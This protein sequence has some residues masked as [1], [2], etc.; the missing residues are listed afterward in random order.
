MCD[1]LFAIENPGC[2]KFVIVFRPAYIPGSQRRGGNLVSRTCSIPV[3]ANALQ[4]HDQRVAG[5]STFDVKGAGFGIASERTANAFGI[6]SAGIDGPCTHSVTRKDLQDRRNRIR[7]K[8]VKLRRLEIV[9]LR[10]IGSDRRAFSGP[11]NLSAARQLSRA[12]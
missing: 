6:Y 7:E 5:Q 12:V 8:P 4:F 10:R 1:S 3:Q 11:S 9:D 2:I